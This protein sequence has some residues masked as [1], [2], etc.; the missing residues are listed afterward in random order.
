MPEEGLAPPFRMRLAGPVVEVGMA[1]D[2]IIQGAI[3]KRQGD[4]VIDAAGRVVGHAGEAVGLGIPF[5]AVVGTVIDGKQ[6]HHAL[7]HVCASMV[8]PVVMEPEKG[9]LLAVVAAG[10]VVEVKIVAPFLRLITLRLPAGIAIAFARGMRIVQMG[11]E[12]PIR[13]AE[14]V[15]VQVQGVLMQPIGEPHAGRLAIHRINHRPREG[16]VEPVNRARGEVPRAC[17]PV[18]RKHW[19]TV[20]PNGLHLGA[21]EIVLTELQIDLVIDWIWRTDIPRGDLMLVVAGGIGPV[22]GG[23][24]GPGPRIGRLEGSGDGKRI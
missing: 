18:R 16:A 21:C 23:G 19:Q 12:A 4:V 8:H 20:G 1:C 7:V 15:A 3:I 13:S 5:V 2:T 22:V 14:I 9:L 10:R 11:Q 17:N 6:P 24:R